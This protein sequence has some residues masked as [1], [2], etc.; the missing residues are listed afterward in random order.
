MAE[1]FI[2]TAD[3]LALHYA[4]PDADGLNII[5]NAFYLAIA[6]CRGNSTKL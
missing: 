5:H 3:M 2:Q 6:L 4:V 1:E